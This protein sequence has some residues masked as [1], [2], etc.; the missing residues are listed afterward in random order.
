MAPTQTEKT[1][2]QDDPFDLDQIDA[3][4]GGQKPFKIKLGGKVY[5]LISTKDVDYR[6]LIAN[7]RLHRDGDSEA[8]IRQLLPEEDH[9][10]FFKNFP[11]TNRM[12]DGMFD[13]YYKHF[14][15]PTLGEANAS[16]GS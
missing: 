1:E 8:A 11:I 10:A 7:G 15:L 14:G 6:E 16:S 3:E 2:T 12:L 5:E 9:A 13:R 4:R